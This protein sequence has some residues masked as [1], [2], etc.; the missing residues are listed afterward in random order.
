MTPATRPDAQMARELIEAGNRNGRSVFLVWPEGIMLGPQPSHGQLELTLIEGDSPSEL[1]GAIRT[2]AKVFLQR[3]DT[4]VLCR[5]LAEG[6]IGHART[7]IK[8]RGNRH[9]VVVLGSPSGTPDW[10]AFIAEHAPATVRLL[11]EV[12]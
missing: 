1:P 10:S 7:A 5:E 3:A 2:A 12:H 11:G 8:E 4:V 6:H 9:V